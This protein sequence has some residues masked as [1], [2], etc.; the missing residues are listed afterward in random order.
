MLSDACSDAV[1]SIEYYEKEYGYDE[2][3]EEI[4]KTK[5]DL[6]LLGMRA[7]N[8]VSAQ[9]AM[10]IRKT[11][12]AHADEVPPHEFAGVVWNAFREVVGEYATGIVAFDLAGQLT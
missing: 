10:A 4:R 3:A 12:L 6:L 9:Q 8:C 1:V 11:A 5:L 7:A 2:L